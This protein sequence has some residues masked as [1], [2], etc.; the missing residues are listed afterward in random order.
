MKRVQNKKAKKT[1]GS[2]QV[3][4]DYFVWKG[5]E[6]KRKPGYLTRSA[7]VIPEGCDGVDNVSRP[8]ARRAV[9]QKDHRHSG[10]DVC[11]S[12]SPMRWLDKRRRCHLPTPVSFS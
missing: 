4:G 10:P 2:T 1:E 12:F 6:T 8:V 11:R 3:D 7:W 5:V 9:L